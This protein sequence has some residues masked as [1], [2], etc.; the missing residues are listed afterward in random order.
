MGDMARARERLEKAQSMDPELHQATR[1]LALVYISQKDYQ[2]AVESSERF[3]AMQPDDVTMMK[4]RMDGYRGLGDDAKADE[5]F[6]ELSAADPA[7]MAASLYQGAE[8]EFNAGNTQAAIDTL[9]RILE[10]DPEHG[11]SHYL[12][13]LSYVNLGDNAK[14]KSHLEAFVKLMPDHENAGPAKSMIEYLK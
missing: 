13:G 12:L 10:I 1:L 2:K 9:N 14:A 8:K 5:V 6:R 7:T 3:L 11:M 4:V